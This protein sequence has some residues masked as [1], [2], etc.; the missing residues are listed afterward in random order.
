M[1]SGAATNVL[2]SLVHVYERDGRATV[3]SVAQAADRT[4]N[5]V[6]RQLAYLRDEGLVDY[7]PGKTGTLRPLVRRVQ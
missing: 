2:L 6:H 1:I 7:T 5:P 4:L 3:R